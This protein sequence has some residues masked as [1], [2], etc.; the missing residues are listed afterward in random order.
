MRTR[1]FKIT[2]ALYLSFGFLLHAQTYRVFYSFPSEQAGNDPTSTLVRDQAGN[3]YGTTFSGGTSFGNNCSLWGGCGTI[4]KITPTGKQTTLFN[5][6]LT[7]TD[8]QNPYSTVA[9]VGNAL[10]G[11]TIYGGVD[12]N[13]TVFKLDSTGHET[14]LHSFTGGTDGK[15]PDAGV[16]P[17]SAGN[18]Y[19]AAQQGGNLADCD[20]GGCGTI[21]KIANDGSFTALYSFTGGADGASPTTTMIRDSQGNLYGVGESGGTGPC[22]GGCGV[23]FK[24]NSSGNETVLYSFNG[25][26][27]D[28]Q[29]PVGPLVRDAAGNLYGT[30]TFGGPHNAGIVY[31]VDPNGNETV[32]YSF[33]QWPAPGGQYP[34]GALLLDKQGNL[35]GGTSTGGQFALG[36]LFKLTQSGELTVLHYF[37]GGP[38]DGGEPDG[39]LTPDGRG[40]VLGTGAIGGTG[41]CPVGCGIVFQ[42]GQ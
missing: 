41:S 4:F 31:K 34:D 15:Y 33:A 29:E 6:G 19:G 36:A 38:N 23:V 40:G 28:G 11:T 26:P 35:Y 1:L 14:I 21:F 37:S 7:S 2:F 17:D 10:Y 25:P 3:L 39:A 20:G 30:T 8:G 22:V 16:V 18:I 5:F 12:G 24:M 9:V 13:G 27:N 42:L 32:L